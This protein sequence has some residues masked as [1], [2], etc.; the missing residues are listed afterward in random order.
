M[1]V[2]ISS[3]WEAAV[4][5]NNNKIS[6]QEVKDGHS[7]SARAYIHTFLLNPQASG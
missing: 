4:N 1:F 5:N 2:S 6:R 7:P 3:Y